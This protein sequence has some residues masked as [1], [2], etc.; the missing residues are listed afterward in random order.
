MQKKGAQRF[1]VARCKS[2]NCTFVSQPRSTPPA[3]PGSPLTPQTMAVLRG[4]E[5]IGR[6]LGSPAFLDRLAAL[7]AYSR[8]ETDDR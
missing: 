1:A 5:T 8:P 4:A 7:A 3:R 2:E 6:R